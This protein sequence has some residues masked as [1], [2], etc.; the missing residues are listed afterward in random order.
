MA[1]GK[2]AARKRKRTNTGVQKENIITD[3][4]QNTPLTRS[5]CQIEVNDLRDINPEEINSSQSLSSH[6]NVTFVPTPGNRP[7]SLSETNPVSL[8]DHEPSLPAPSQPP[9]PRQQHPL[10]RSLETTYAVSE[11]DS[12]ITT[13][14][15]TMVSP[16]VSEHTSSTQSDFSADSLLNETLNPIPLR[17]QKQKLMFD[18]EDLDTWEKFETDVGIYIYTVNVF[19]DTAES[20]EAADNLAIKYTSEIINLEKYD[21]EADK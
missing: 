16:I 17:K 21:Y 20:N 4:Q 7:V 6:S 12:F 1:G 15:L 13:A 14:S 11:A 18:P 5:Q 3:G 10:L 8:L 19:P 2:V 9:L